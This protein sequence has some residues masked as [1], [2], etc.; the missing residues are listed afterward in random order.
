MEFVCSSGITV[1]LAT[2]TLWLAGCNGSGVVADAGLDASGAGTDAPIA[3]GADVPGGSDGGGGTDVPSTITGDAIGGTDLG[4]G[5]DVDPGGGDAVAGHDGASPPP[6]D[7]GTP[8]MS[9]S[10]VPPVTSGA[11]TYYGTANGLPE[12]D[13]RGI[14]VGPHGDVAVTTN[15]GLYVMR[16]GTSGFRHYTAADG[17]RM[18]PAGQ[19]CQLATVAALPGGDWVV[20]YRGVWLDQA[21]EDNDPPEYKQ[22]GDA[23]RIRIAADGSLSRVMH[24]NITP[25]PTVADPVERVRTVYT[26]IP[27]IDGQ[28]AGDIWFGGNHGVGMWVNRFNTIEQHQHSALGFWDG[29]A[30]QFKTGEFFGVAI[31][32]EGNTWI[33]GSER[34]ALLHYADDGGDFWGR[35]EPEVDAPNGDQW[36][37][38]DI[39]PDDATHSAATRDDVSSMTFASDGGLWIGSASQGL[40]RLDTVSRVPSYVEVPDKAVLA[41]R[42]DG[43]TLWVGMARGGLMR[44]DLSART[45]QQITGLPANGVYAMSDDTLAHPHTRTIWMSGYGFVAAYNGQ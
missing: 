5:A 29:H 11:F 33:G 23:D 41:L 38:L 8:D 40:A 35:L 34:V 32:P 21:N 1:V 9:F 2:A 13:L 24:Y 17:L 16:A 7:G 6:P 19:P 22:S 28:Y 12:D 30:Q 36:I 18:C 31:D 20:G 43:N 39:W 44:L 10:Q 45:R 42:A 3:T 25:D 14:A 26:V 15:G 37:G 27:V 4:G